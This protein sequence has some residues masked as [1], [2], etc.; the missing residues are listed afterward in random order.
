MIVPADE[1]R[2]AV[3]GL[4]L[5]R[6]QSLRRL[7]LA[8]SRADIALLSELETELDYVVF[9]FGSR[10]GVEYAVEVLELL[11]A[12]FYLSRELFLGGDAFFVLGVIMLGV[13]SRSFA[14][15]ELYLDCGTVLGVEILDLCRSVALLDTVD[16]RGDEVAPELV[17]VLFGAGCELLLLD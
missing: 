12:L 6:R 13:L 10:E 14:H 5:Y 16:I 2:V 17:G 4:V 11:L 7:R 15:I 8:A 9:G 3:R 1:Y